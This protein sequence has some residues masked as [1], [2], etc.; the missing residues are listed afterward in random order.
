MPEGTKDGSEKE[1][2]ESMLASRPVQTVNNEG[3]EEMKTVELLRANG[4]KLFQP[5]IPEARG[6][7]WKL[8]W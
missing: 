4:W 8:W 1:E 7:W 6:K 2:A 5:E 3:N